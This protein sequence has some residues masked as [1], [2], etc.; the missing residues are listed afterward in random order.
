MKYPF[1][2][3]TVMTLFVERMIG[4][5]NQVDLFTG[6]FDGIIATIDEEDFPTPDKSAISRWITGARSIPE[7][8]VERCKD[9]DT[10]AIVEADI[11]NMILEHLSDVPKLIYQLIR[12]LRDDDSFTDVGK[13]ELLKYDPH[14]DMNHPRFLARVVVL[15]VRSD[16]RIKYDRKSFINSFGRRPS[17]NYFRGSY[18]PL[19]Q[20]YFTGR[21]KEK[22]EIDLLLKEKRIV[23]LFGTRGIGKS[24]LA[25][26]YAKSTSSFSTSIW[27]PYE[28]SLRQ[29]I[30]SL[31]LRHQMDESKMS[32]YEQN[33]RWLK[34]QDQSTLIILDNFDVLE[35]EEELFFEFMNCGCT[36]LVTSHVHHENVF[37][38][39]VPEMEIEELRTLFRHY[40]TRKALT[41]SQVDEIIEAGHHHTMIVEMAAKLM[42]TSNV[43]QDMLVEELRKSVAELDLPVNVLLSKD[44]HTKN[45]IIKA[46]I[47]ALFDLSAL[48]HQQLRILVLMSYMPIDGI[49]ANLFCDWA[50]DHYHNVVTRLVRMGWLDQLESSDQTKMHPVISELLHTRCGDYENAVLRF[51]QR[52]VDCFRNKPLR[53]EEDQVKATLAVSQRITDFNSPDWLT[54]QFDNA[55]TIQDSGRKNTALACMEQ[56]VSQ[57]AVRE[58]TNYFKTFAYYRIGC[59]YSEM[60]RYEAALGCFERALSF[61]ARKHMKDSGYCSLLV[62]CLLECALL[63]AILNNKTVSNRFM[64][65]LTQLIELLPENEA[66]RLRSRTLYKQGEIYRLLDDHDE[67][68]RAF[69]EALVKREKLFGADSEEAALAHAQLGLSY[70]KKDDDW[71]AAQELYKAYLLLKKHMPE[72]HPNLVSIQLSLG[73]ALENIT[74]E[75]LGIAQLLDML[76][77]A[78]TEVDLEA[79]T[80]ELLPKLKR[81][82]DNWQQTDDSAK[83]KGRNFPEIQAAL[84]TIKELILEFSVSHLKLMRKEYGWKTYSRLPNVEPRLPLRFVQ[85]R[86][87]SY[88]LET[89]MKMKDYHQNQRAFMKICHGPVD[90][91]MIEKLKNF[92]YEPPLP[93]RAIRADERPFADL[94]GEAAGRMLFHGLIDGNIY[95]FE[96]LSNP[97]MPMPRVPQK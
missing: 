29:T 40:Y 55:C 72:T 83:E 21:E 16:R 85:N 24:A 31:V 36:I 30:E 18:I 67:A 46:H 76:A 84:E 66:E 77:G 94:L 97:T 81:I 5:F 59:L 56:I 9:D 58:C 63:Y 50:D 26:D 74:G 51:L 8:F 33:F 6:M 89:E 13:E 11:R 82:S 78:S 41:D 35:E 7:I 69:Q 17:D 22:G 68:I 45:A 92:Q 65:F 42:Q 20:P 34:S 52:M 3:S 90:T 49:H 87:E 15:A 71:N 54:V 73:I 48:T 91:E 53:Y 10:E 70:R 32:P 44:G 93:N 86:A 2:F 75:D 80:D 38:Y 96:M 39:L 27:M 47:N 19:L 14:Y 28:G 25:A 64:E 62:N 37:E 1:Q 23:F 61:D 95:W 12:L 43:K 60:A 57:P 79:F 4:K 88:S